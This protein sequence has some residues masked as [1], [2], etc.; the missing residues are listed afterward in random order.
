MS[1]FAEFVR[2]QMAGFGPVTIRGMFGG[3]GVFYDGLMFALI[4]DDEL[5]FK[6]DGE[7]RGRFEARGLEPFR[8]SQRGKTVSF[9]YFAA[10]EEV[11]DSTDAMAEWA[12]LAW[13]AALRAVNENSEAKTK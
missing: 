12:K 11:F 2:E 9:N 13:G 5:Y 3:S 6:A 4:V 7:T 8:Y 10:P 1:E